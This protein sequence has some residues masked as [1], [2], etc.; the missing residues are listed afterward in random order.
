M[1]K[2][3]GETDD[4]SRPMC[5]NMSSN[6]VRRCIYS[7][8]SSIAV[9]SLLDRS[10]VHLCLTSYSEDRSRYLP[11]GTVY[12]PFAGDSRQ[13]SYR[14]VVQPGDSQTHPSAY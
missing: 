5:E 10:H 13:Y 6:D 7:I 12:V 11:R 4:W 14:H 1:Q 9:M 2:Q 3:V 8:R